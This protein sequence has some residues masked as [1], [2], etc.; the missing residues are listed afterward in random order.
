MAPNS[1]FYQQSY[2]FTL[3]SKKKQDLNYFP[4]EISKG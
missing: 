3:D 2:Q 1:E 4:Q